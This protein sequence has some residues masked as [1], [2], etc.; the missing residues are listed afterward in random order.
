[1]TDRYSPEDHLGER[2]S[3]I[4]AAYVILRR[5][6]EVLLQ[7]RAGTGYRDGYW[8][9]LAGHVD[10]GET[11]HEAAVR[12]ALEEAGVTIDPA[13]LRPLTAMHRFEREGPAVEQRVDFFFEATQW[14]DDPALR[15]ADKA[16]AMGWYRLDALP[17][18]V[19]P[20]ELDVLRLLQ[21]GL[22]VPAVIS[23]PT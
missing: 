16:S 3:L 1:V 9:V 15:E 19:V 5:G 14:S 12:E 2:T 18:P 13:A 10:P 17:E 7:Q 11:A 8:A 4:A 21:E 23:L 6:D 20:H 22:P